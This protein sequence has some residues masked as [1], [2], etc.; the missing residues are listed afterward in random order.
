MTGAPETRTGM[1]AP[2]K[3]KAEHSRSSDNPELSAHETRNSG[4]SQYLTVEDVA[5]LIKVSPAW[6]RA[7]ANGNR[8]PRMPSIKLGKYRRFRHQAVLDFIHALEGNFNA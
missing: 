2:T 6:V 4:L 7:H 1:S 3:R 5:E 8:N